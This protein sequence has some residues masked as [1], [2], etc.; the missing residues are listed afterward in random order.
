MAELHKPIQNSIQDFRL[1]G[2]DR[3]YVGGQ[4]NSTALTTV[5]PTL[6]AIYFTPFSVAKPTPLDRIAFSVATIS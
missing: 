4:F 1:P 2:S 3:Y 5:T 6:N